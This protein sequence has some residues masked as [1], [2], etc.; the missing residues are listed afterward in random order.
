MSDIFG[1]K[2]IV[3]LDFGLFIV[4]SAACG[5]AHTFTQLVVFRAFQGIGA[6]GYTLCSIVFLEL[7]PEEKY[8]KY[9]AAISIVYALSLSLGPV[10]GGVIN[11]H[12]SWRWVFLLK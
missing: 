11:D 3:L 1:R 6:A 12:S 8:V 5:A 10:L 9:N 4:F 2:S 7:I